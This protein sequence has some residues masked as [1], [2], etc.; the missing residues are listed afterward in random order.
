MNN[1]FGLGAGLGLVTVLIGGGAAI[2]SGALVLPGGNEILTLAGPV[3]S[4]FTR[5]G[6]LPLGAPPASANVVEV[7]FTCLSAGNFVFPTE[8][9]DPTHPADPMLL[10]EVMCSEPNNESAITGLIPLCA[11]SGTELTVATS[12]DASWSLTAQYVN[13]EV[14]GWATN[15]SGHSFGLHNENGDPEL[16]RV[17]ATNGELGYAYRQGLDGG[18][19]P[20]TPE[21]AAAWNE[22]HTADRVIPVFESDGQTIIGEFVLQGVDLVEILGVDENGVAEEIRI[23]SSR[24]PNGA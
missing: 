19:A 7:T 1:K 9:V 4:T 17:Q 13:K 23:T 16:V 6:S 12:P 5:N 22:S 24:V 8:P 10:T 15:A 3:G 2:A 20:T 21:E 18:P 14:T 11:L